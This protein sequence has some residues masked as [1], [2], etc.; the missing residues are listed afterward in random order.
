MRVQQVACD[1]E[2]PDIDVHVEAGGHESPRHTEVGLALEDLCLIA[3]QQRFLVAAGGAMGHYGIQQDTEGTHRGLT[4]RWQGKRFGKSF[5]GAFPV[6]QA[7]ESKSV[8]RQHRAQRGNVT[9]TYRRDLRPRSPT[10][11]LD[12]IPA[13]TNDFRESEASRPAL[14]LDRRPSALRDSSGFLGGL[15]SFVAPVR[16][17]GRERK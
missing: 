2:C 4:R 14:A 7:T 1:V 8:L 16:V 9:S 12:V 3:H 15:Q 11:P 13:R 5:A 6:T 10:Q 17:E